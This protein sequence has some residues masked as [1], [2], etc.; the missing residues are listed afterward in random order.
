MRQLPAQFPLPT[1]ELFLAHNPDTCKDNTDNQ[2]EQ[3]RTP[4]SGRK[5]AHKQRPGSLAEFRL[6]A[7]RWGLF[8]SSLPIRRWFLYFPYL[9]P[10][11][12]C[13]GLR[14]L[15]LIA[16]P[17]MRFPNLSSIEYC[18]PSAE[19]RLETLLVTGRLGPTAALPQR[20]PALCLANSYCY[21]STV[22]AEL[23]PVDRSKRREFAPG[24]DRGTARSAQ[25]E[26]PI[27][28]SEASAPLP[29]PRLLCS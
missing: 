17:R 7:G 21:S 1:S 16:A 12:A 19:P 13:A 3:A 5:R 2:Q 14:P 28:H 20:P 8:R 26:N 6:P 29:C 9:E 25:P 15:R 24:A 23:L 4:Q 22:E 11:H 18:P 27:H 10:S